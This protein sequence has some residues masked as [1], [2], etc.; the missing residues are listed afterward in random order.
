MQRIR[1]QT[2][3]FSV[4]GEWQALRERLDVNAGAVAAF[5]GLVREVQGDSGS[6]LEIEH[7]AGMTERSV[8][9]IVAE[10]ERRWRLAA[11]TVI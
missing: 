7:Y 10:A 4:D 8:T 9:A 6:S 2:G 5:V 11:V 3:D 1:I